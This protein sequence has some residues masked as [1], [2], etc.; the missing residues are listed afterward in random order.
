MI[1]DHSRLVFPGLR[2]KPRTC[3]IRLSERDLTWPVPPAIRPTGKI[4]SMASPSRALAGC[5]NFPPSRDLS[6]TSRA[7]SRR[8]TT[9]LLPK[10]LLDNRIRNEGD[11]VASSQLTRWIR[12]SSASAAAAPAR[13]MGGA[14]AIP[15]NGWF[16]AC[17]SPPPRVEYGW[18]TSYPP[19]IS[20][21]LVGA[22]GSSLRRPS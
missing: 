18:I 11:V 1:P 14:K 5:A 17:A 13:R 22:T 2:Q 9:G 16:A 3:A 15:I 21:M 6:N 20:L 4:R 19:S 8:E 12:R 10:P 7:Q